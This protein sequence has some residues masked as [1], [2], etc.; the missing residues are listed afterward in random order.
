MWGQAKL[1]AGDRC[2]FSG[3]NDAERRA[4]ADFAGD[5]NLARH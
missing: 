5:F 2:Y 4:L 3:E 1:F